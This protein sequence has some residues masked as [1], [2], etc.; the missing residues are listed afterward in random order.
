ML[1]LV[2]ACIRAFNLHESACN[3][4]E[5]SHHG[6]DFVVGLDQSLRNLSAVIR[7]EHKN[8][9]LDIITTLYLNQF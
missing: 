8:I 6:L 9:R 3:F 4:N 7:S 5:V 1:M 2:H